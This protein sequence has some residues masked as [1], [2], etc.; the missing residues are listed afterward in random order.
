MVRLTDIAQ[1]VNLDVSVVSRALNP[2]PDRH[3]VIREETRLLIRETAHKLGY[4]PNRQASFLKKGSAATILCFLPDT[5]DR[6]IADLMMGISET[7]CHENFPVN[8]FFGSNAGDFGRFIRQAERIGHSG[9]ISYPPVKMPP[10]MRLELERYHQRGGRILLLNVISN[11]SGGRLDREYSGIPQLNI[12][13]FY[14]GQLVAKHFLE[15]GCGRFYYRPEV[16]SYRDR[17]G[18]FKAALAAEGFSAEELTDAVLGTLK[19]AG[20]KAGIFAE[21]DFIAYKLLNKMS[22]LGLQP[23][24]RLLLA[25]FDDQVASI[26]FE[27]S[28]TTVHQPTRQEGRLAVDKLIR[29]IYGGREENE[30]LKPYLVIRETSGGSRP[31]PENRTHEEVIT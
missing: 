4:R 9:I 1:A 11:T 26:R 18:G 31:D 6:L 28:L 13:D 27:P 10:E 25:G 20:G 23:G 24:G 2:N 7:A 30:T 19:D 12:D 16:R 15:R 29:M 8:F 21:H 17:L 5:A 14:G 22:G 3:A